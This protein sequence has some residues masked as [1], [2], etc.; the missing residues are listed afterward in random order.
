MSAGFQ[1]HSYSLTSLKKNGTNGKTKMRTDT[2]H[3]S[4][5]TGAQPAIAKFQTFRERFQQ[6]EGSH[7]LQPP[8]LQESLPCA[9]AAF[10]KPKSSPKVSR[11]IMPPYV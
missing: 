6:R 8:K 2:I 9:A 4:S 3:V 5:T 1:F 10:E 11:M 7:F